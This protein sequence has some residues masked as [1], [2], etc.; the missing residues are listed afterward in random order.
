[1]SRIALIT[2]ARS[3]AALDIARDFS[4]AGY[5][6]HMADSRRAR[7]A[8]WSNTPEKVHLIAPPV[9][10]PVGFRRD[11]AALVDRLDP[12]IVVPTCEE[13]FHLAAAREDGVN[14]GPLFAPPL[15]T[16]DR[17]HSK[18]RFAAEVL[19]LGLNVP[20]TRLATDA[21]DPD[22]IELDRVVLKACYS[23]FGSGTLIRPTRADVA[24]LKPTKADPWIVQDLIIGTEYSS[25]TAAIGGKVV[26]FATYLSSL[27]LKGGAG[28]A[29]TPAKPEIRGRL[30]EAASAVAAAF[31]LTGQFAFDAIDDGERTWLIECN[32]R[33]TSGV[34]LLTR[35]GELAK[36]M[37]GANG[38]AEG[39]GE[40]RQNLP[41][42][43]SYGLLARLSGQGA[44]WRRLIAAQDV[45][46]APGDR[47]PLL[48]AIFDTVSFA[49]AA[50]RQGA[51][52]TGATTSDIEWNGGGR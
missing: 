44:D 50:R 37:T 2:G 47:L 11:V 31:G 29:F 36:A 51:T 10:D 46:G 27:K 30:L 9:Q 48:G 49:I 38:F 12:E 8:R 23:R 13:V 22:A 4:A 35:N 7:L 14:V 52:L 32:P 17:L 24:A 34:H 39:R 21:L 33:A 28:Y 25:Y 1:M 40:S 42:M 15:S 19:A 43:L 41:M 5:R 16:L 3:P 20:K 26:A 45:I 6:V 18:D